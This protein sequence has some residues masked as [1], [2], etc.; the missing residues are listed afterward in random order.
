MELER[1][2]SVIKAR[3]V[4]EQAHRPKEELGRDHFEG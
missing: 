2:A 4:R 3:R 1:L